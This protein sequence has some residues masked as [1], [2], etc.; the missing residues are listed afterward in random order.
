MN[1]SKVSCGNLLTCAVVGEEVM[2]FLKF[3]VRDES[4]LDNGFVV[5]EHM[6]AFIDRDAAVTKHVAKINDL[7]SAQTSG[8]ELGP[9]CRSFGGVLLLD[10]PFNESLIEAMQNLSHEAFC[11]NVVHEVGINT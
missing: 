4:S 11:E 8:N 1:K 5:T 10:K 9:A 6:S 3:R 7:F 2:A